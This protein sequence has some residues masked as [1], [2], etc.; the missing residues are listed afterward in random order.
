MR[1]SL[2][3]ALHPCEP[4]RAADRD[5]EIG[6]ET[7]RER[8]HP[9][10]HPELLSACP[11]ILDKHVCGNVLHLTHHVE[12]TQTVETYG[13]VRHGVEG[14]PMLVIDLAD[15]VQPVVDQSAP[16]AIDGRGD[17]A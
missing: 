4:V 11:G 14:M 8:V 2:L 17:A 7:V 12:F 3:L 5:V 16:L 10:V 9:A 13:L 15:R 6:N 1:A